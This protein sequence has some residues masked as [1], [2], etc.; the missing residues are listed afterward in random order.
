MNQ[1][2]AQTMKQQ[3]HM[4]VA[5]IHHAHCIMKVESAVTGWAA[6]HSQM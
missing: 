6:I 1:V 4:H 2:L 5:L 3:L